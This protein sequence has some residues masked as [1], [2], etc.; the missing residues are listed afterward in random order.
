MRSWSSFDYRSPPGSGIWNVDRPIARALSSNVIPPMSTPESTYWSLRWQLIGVAKTAV[1]AAYGEY[2]PQLTREAREAD[3]KMVAGLI[4]HI[5]TFLAWQGKIE[6]LMRRTDV[7]W[8]A[9]EGLPEYRAAGKA[10]ELR[11]LLKEWSRSNAPIASR[12]D[13]TDHLAIHFLEALEAWWHHATSD[14]PISGLFFELAASI[15]RDTELFPEHDSAEDD[16]EGWLARRYRTTKR[17]LRKKGQ[18]GK[19]RTDPSS[20]SDP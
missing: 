4:G 3:F 1:I 18:S 12:G 11:E 19:D 20:M 7:P 10:K 17:P 9:L 14:Y 2:L 16:I 6:D 15:C 5:D 8:Q 13:A